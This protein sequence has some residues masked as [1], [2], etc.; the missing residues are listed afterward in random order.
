MEDVKKYTVISTILSQASIFYG[1]IRFSPPFCFPSSSW[2]KLEFN[3]GKQDTNHDRD[4]TT[5]REEE[6]LRNQSMASSTRIFGNCCRAL[7]AAAK[8]S[9]ATTTTTATVTKRRGRP[10]GIV[11]PQAV[12]PALANFLGTNEASRTHAVKKV[13]EYIKSHNLQNPAN[14]R[15]IHCDDKLKTIFD[16]KDKVG[17]LEIARLLTQHFQKAA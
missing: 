13:W 4:E 1:L 3:G 6:N 17:F 10:N 5:V 15:E 9:T 14:K 11:K 12:S 7:M 16:G 8:T 2:G